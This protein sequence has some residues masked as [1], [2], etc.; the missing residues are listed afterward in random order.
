MHGV[1]VCAKSLLDPASTAKPLLIHE[2]TMLSKVR[3]PNIVHLLG[4]QTFKQ[5]FQLLTFF[6]YSV[7]G[8]SVSVSDTLYSTHRARRERER[9]CHKAVADLSEAAAA[10]REGRLSRRRERDRARHETAA[11]REGRLSRRRERDG[12]RALHE[13]TEERE[14]RL[15]R[16]REQHRARHAAHREEQL[17]ERRSGVGLQELM[18]AETPEAREARL[19]QLA[20]RQQER[21]ASATPE[22]REVRLQHDCLRHQFQRYQPL[23][24]QSAIQEKMRKFHC[25]LASLETPKCSTCLEM[26][27]GMHIVSGSVECV[28][29]SKDHNTPKRFSVANNMDPGSVPSQLQVRFKIIVSKCSYYCCIIQNLTQVEEMLISAV[30]PV[31]TL[32]RLR[33]GQYGYSGHVVNLPQDITSFASILPRHPQDLDVL[34]VRREGS[35]QSHHDFQVRRSVVL[36]AL[37]WLVDNNIYYRNITIDPEVVA[38]LPEDGDVSSL[39][40]VTLDTTPE[41]PCPSQVEED[42]YQSELSRSFVPSAP[43]RSTEVEAIQR[44]VHR[45]VSSQP[46]QAV[47]WPATGAPVS[48]F[49]TE[50][51]MTCAFPTLFP[52]GSADFLAP[53]V[54]AVAVDQYFKHLMMYEDKQFATHPHFR[55][56]ALNIEMRWRALQTGRV[57][58][59]PASK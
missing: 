52:T 22:A 42:P 45:D 29:C 16:R 13:T 56:F 1:L 53:R 7:A 17:L 27:P 50:G 11:E 54:N 12:E 20:D 58:I 38:Q 4:V 21:R 46:P 8:V 28:R 47:P 55:Y 34:I 26:F 48:E 6:F 9:S 24:H 3:H 14:E 40:T 59:Q 10:E 18:E 43:R 33:Q 36:H 2:A 23:L 25:H 49:T 41:E 32:Y 57:Y 51:Y 5:P 30:M 35:N 15:S 39:C 37:Q 31:M 19:Q 44:I